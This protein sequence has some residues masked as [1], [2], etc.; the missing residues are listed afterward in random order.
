[1]RSR[2]PDGRAANPM[3]DERHHHGA[4]RPGSPLDV[5]REEPSFPPKPLRPAPPRPPAHTIIPAMPLLARIG[6]FTVLAGLGEGGMGIVYSAYDDQLDRKVAVKVLRGDT[7]RRDPQARER[8]LREAQAMARVSHP[9]IVT[10]HEVGAQDGEI[11]IAMEFIRGH[12]LGGW[13]QLSPRSW[14][15]VIGALLQAGRG[16]AAAHAAGLIH[17]DFKPANVLVATDG[18]VKVLDFGLARAV[19]SPSPEALA[20]LRTTNSTSLDTALTR[21]GTVLG[22]PAYMAPERRP[23]TRPRCWRSPTR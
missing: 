10:V 3:T 7:M 17:R 15:E 12:S 8:L 23:S 20:P 13:L 16:L 6:R 19:D 22:T 18:V 5:T 11:F 4:A 14:R 21:T 9:N 1:M 2:G